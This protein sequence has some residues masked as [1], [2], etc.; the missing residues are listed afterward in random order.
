MRVSAVDLVGAEVDGGGVELA[1]LVEQVVFMA[2]AAP[3]EVNPSVRAWS[4]S[5]TSA[6]EPIVRL[7]RM[8]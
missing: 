5:A 4:P 1:E 7:T 6:A 3:S 2:P 8:R